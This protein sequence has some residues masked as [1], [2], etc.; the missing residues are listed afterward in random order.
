[1]LSYRTSSHAERFSLHLLHRDSICLTHP[2]IRPSSPPLRVNLQSGDDES[3]EPQIRSDVLVMAT[4][5]FGSFERR[6]LP[7]LAGAVASPATKVS[8]A[9]GEAAAG[10][11]DN[12]EDLGT[13]NGAPP[14]PIAR[15]LSE[16]SMW[17]INVNAM[18]MYMR[19]VDL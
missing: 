5:W 19:M 12:R 15:A 3:D 2:E 9:A 14:A 6:F 11:N 4:E 1:M 10:T 17:G 18:H 16:V 7:S 8:A 13:R